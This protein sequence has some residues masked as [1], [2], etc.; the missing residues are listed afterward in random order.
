MPTSEARA[1]LLLLALAVLGQGVRHFLTRPGQPPGQVQLLGALPPASPDA[2]R[3][4]ALRQ[5][6][7][8]GPTERINVDLASPTELTRL[9]KVGI[10]LAKVIVADRQAHGSFGSL[11]GLDRV[12]GIGPGLLKTLSPHV[13]FSGSAGL[14]GSPLSATVTPAPASRSETS[15]LDLNTASIS[16]L[17]ALPGIGPSKAAAILQYRERQ[18]RFSSV[19]ELERVPGFGPAAVSRLRDQLVAR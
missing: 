19:D 11:A 4:S 8:L 9:P 13:A 17:D 14:P 16:E 15:P 18:G 12:S 3:D 5:G 7:P 6:R 1:M 10:R 2:Q